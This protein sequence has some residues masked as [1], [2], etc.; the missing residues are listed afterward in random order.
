MN[1]RQGMGVLPNIFCCS[2]VRMDTKSTLID[3]DPTNG[4]LSNALQTLVFGALLLLHRVKAS[5]AD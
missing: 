4:Q 2:N 1:D 3:T 5:A